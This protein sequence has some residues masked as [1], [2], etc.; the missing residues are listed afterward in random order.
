MVTSGSA[1]TSH[2]DS[3]QV[4]PEGACLCLYQVSHMYLVHNS[5]LQGK[6]DAIARHWTGLETEQREGQQGVGGSV[7]GKVLV[8][9]TQWLQFSS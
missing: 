2:S 6:P 8:M 3:G 1:A 4:L 5:V 7:V 9:Q